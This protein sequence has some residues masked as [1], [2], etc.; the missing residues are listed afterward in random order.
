MASRPAVGVPLLGTLVHP[1]VGV[2]LVG[3]LVHPRVGAPLVRPS[4]IPA[5]IPH[6]PHP[7]LAR[8]RSPST[9]IR[10]LHRGPQTANRII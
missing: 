4:S 10:P 6:L 8:L 7:N 2:P 3:T 1:R 9:Q 5:P